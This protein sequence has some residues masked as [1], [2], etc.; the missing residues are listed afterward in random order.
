[1]EKGDHK[2]MV[3]Y[4]A[5]LLPYSVNEGVL[6]V[7]IAHMGGPFWSRKN[8]GAWSVVKGEYAPDAEDKEAAAFRE[9]KE[10]V[11]VSLGGTPLFLGDFKQPSGKI[12]SVFIS[13]Q[14]DMSL[15]FVSSNEFE[16]EWPKGSGNFQSFPE[17]D[18]AE[19][20]NIA[21]AKEYLLKG[22]I[23]ILTA[24]FKELRKTDP[25]LLEEADEQSYLF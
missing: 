14:N 11:G 9:F 5:A 13:R 23:P 20:F 12:I 18:K 3:T 4:S 24:L 6:N 10:E 2:T 21:S 8:K 7:F 16:M 1:M 22:Q 15:S 19:W 25:S 17:I